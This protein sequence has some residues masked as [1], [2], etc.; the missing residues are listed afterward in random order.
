MRK[1]I[2]SFFLL[3]ILLLILWVASA[4]FFGS[5]TKDM[6]NTFSTREYLSDNQSF[7]K[8]LEY[9]VIESN[10]TILGTKLKVSLIPKN[11]NIIWSIFGNFKEDL[12]LNIDIIN[13][14]LLFEKSGL[15]IGR[16]KWIVSF[17]EK[18]YSSLLSQYKFKNLPKAL[19]TIGFDKQLDYKLAI[20]TQLNKININGELDP[21]THTGKGIVEAE[22]FIFKT[23][24]QVIN[25]K[26]A[27]VTYT[28][29]STQSD[30]A[31]FN[32]STDIPELLFQHQLMTDPLLMTV[33]GKGLIS[34]G[35][36]ILSSSNSFSFKQSRVSNYPP[37]TADLTFNIND[38]SLESL[39]NVIDGFDAVINLKEQTQ[40]VLEEQS[41]LPEGQDKIWELQDNLETSVADLPSII[42]GLLVKNESSKVSFTLETQYKNNSS[43]LKGTILPLSESALS[44]LDANSDD[45]IWSLLKAVSK[46]TLDKSLLSYVSTHLPINKSK[47]DLI[48]QQNKL[49][50]Q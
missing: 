37:E 36:D 6:L 10:S 15:S 32:W 2:S 21:I 48:Y 43:N 46:V 45:S 29:Q 14:P 7:L 44:N 34:I 27:K 33:K 13:G 28:H 42:E 49:L 40:W 18:E 39:L 4:W 50:M 19:I 47:F 41:E 12:K 26:Q 23:G 30:E 9:K 17:D 1:T 22:E 25:S 5:Q 3:L 11:E 38:L 24:K 31:K 16:S 35:N 8:D 20:D